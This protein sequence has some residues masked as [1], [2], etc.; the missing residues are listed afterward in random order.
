MERQFHCHVQLPGSSS[1]VDDVDEVALAGVD[2][3]CDGWAAAVVDDG[4]VA[5]VGE[6]LAVA[7]DAAEAAAATFTC[8]TGPLSP[9]L[10][11]RTVTLTLLGAVCT[12]PE[13]ACEAGA[14]AVGTG[15]AI[16]VVVSAG[17]TVVSGI[18]PL[19]SGVSVVDGAVVDAGASAPGSP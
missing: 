19:G 3:A 6:A 15:P 13:D 9:G 10:P 5:A 8:V 1:D 12:A 16:S 17:S 4:V 7:V 18:G 14:A 2:T 11:M